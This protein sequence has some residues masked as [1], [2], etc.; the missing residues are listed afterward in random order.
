MSTAYC[1][2]I[3]TLTKSV[4]VG[5]LTFALKTSLLLRLQAVDTFQYGNQHT[6][7]NACDAQHEPHLCTAMHRT[8]ADLCAQNSISHI[9]CM[10]WH[11]SLS[12]HN[13]IQPVK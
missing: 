13:R 7:S 1:S 3:R 12:C 2:I 11:H 4:A 10:L 8:A 6:H 5:L 9:V